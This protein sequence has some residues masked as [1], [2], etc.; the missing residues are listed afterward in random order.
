MLGVLELEELFLTE[1]PDLNGELSSSFPSLSR[2]SL[3]PPF[4]LFFLSRLRH[5]VPTSTSLQTRRRSRRI[6]QRRKVVDHQRPPRWEASLGFGYSRKDEAL[7]DAHLHGGDHP[8]RLPRTRLPS[9]RHLKGRA[10][11][12]WSAPHRSDEGVHG[13]DGVGLQEGAEGGVGGNVRHSD[14]G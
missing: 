8:L 14:R 2:L 10:R 5:P 6:P 4:L 1:S 9:V 13:A 12:R 7:P 3:I 11:L